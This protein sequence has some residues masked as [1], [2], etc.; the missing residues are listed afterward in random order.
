MWFEQFTI[1]VNRCHHN[2][3]QIHFHFPQGSSSQG[4]GVILASHNFHL[5]LQSFGNEEWR[6]EDDLPS[7][8]YLAAAEAMAISPPEI[9]ALDWYTSSAPSASRLLT[10]WNIMW[11]FF[12]R[13]QA[14]IGS[15]LAWFKWLC[16]K[17]CYRTNVED[18]EEGGDQLRHSSLAVS[19]L[20]LMR[21]TVCTAPRNCEMFKKNLLWTPAVYQL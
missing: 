10:D 8:V 17:A 5:Q 9:L 18:E 12:T 2:N 3:S 20:I 21:S 13:C 11:I 7:I 16:R 19:V 14:S 6:Q 15:N 4:S 1:V